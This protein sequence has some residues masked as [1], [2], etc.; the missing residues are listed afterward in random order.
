MVTL[1][2][3]KAQLDTNSQLFM[4]HSTLKPV[5]GQIVNT[6]PE[7]MALV[8]LRNNIMIA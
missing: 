5:F 4:K 6:H 7:Q 8:Y 3:E 2:G 1:R